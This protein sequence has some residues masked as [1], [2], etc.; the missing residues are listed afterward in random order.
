MHAGVPQGTWLEP[1][2]FSAAINDACQ[3]LDNSTFCWKYV[4]DL[5]LI[6]C[7][8]SQDQSQ[9]Q[10]SIDSLVQWS[11]T[12][13]MK[14]NPQKCNSMEITFSRSPQ[15]PQALEINSHPLT[16]SQT[17]KL[18]GVHIQQDLKWGRISTVYSNELTVEFI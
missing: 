17:V 10:Q 13:N 7:R 15:P 16:Q 5:N 1:V 11:A 9:M 14:L 4:D 12:N 18:L 6:E 2:V 8:S 3:N